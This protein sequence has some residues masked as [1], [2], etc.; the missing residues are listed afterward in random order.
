MI[1]R[2]TLLT[3]ALVCV[4]LAAQQP[5][6]GAPFPLTNTRYGATE[7][8]PM[9]T[10]N[11]QEAFLFW[12]TSR[13]I[14]VTR[15][16]S[17]EKPLGRVV[18]SDAE[19]FT[20]L[21]A[22]THFLLVA[23]RPEKGVPD[24]LVA[25]L[26]D[27]SGEPLGPEFPLLRY[28]HRPA[29]AFNGTKVLLLC[30][31]SA[32][33]EAI[34]LNA[35]GTPASA[36]APTVVHQATYDP[37]NRYFVDADYSVAR[38][39]TGF[40]AAVGVQAMEIVVF[41]SDGTI[42]GRQT[43]SGADVPQY[44][45]RVPAI[46]AGTDNTFFACWR[47]GFGD[48]QALY[49]SILDGEGVPDHV[50]LIERTSSF[51]PSIA[52]GNGYD[53]VYA[54]VSPPSYP[55]TKAHIDRTGVVSREPVGDTAFGA[56]SATTLNNRTLIAWT[57]AGAVYGRDSARPA[58]EAL[59]FGA[60]E[61]SAMTTAAMGDSTL[62]AWHERDGVHAGIR[63]SNGDWSERLIGGGYPLLASSGANLFV[64]ITV[65]DRFHAIRLTAQGEPADSPID[66]ADDFSPTS[67]AWNGSEFALI[68]LDLKYNILAST[69]TPAG[70]VSPS[71][72]LARDT[73]RFGLS[74][75]VI[76]SD[77][78]GFFAAWIGLD[79][80]TFPCASASGVFATRLDADLRRLDAANLTIASPDAC[81]DVTVA[82]DGT[83]YL[84][85]WT[86]YY[87]VLLRRVSTAGVLEPPVLANP[88]APSRHL[89]TTLTPIA[90]GA[91]LAWRQRD[92]PASDHVTLVRNGVVTE[93]GSFPIDV[94]SSAPVLIAGENTLG[95]LVTSSQN[96]APYYGSMRTMMALADVALPPP[97]SPPRATLRQES[98][99][100]LLIEWTAPPEKVNG[101][102]VETLVGPNTW[103]EIDS[104][105]YFRT[106]SLSVTA[107]TLG[108][109]YRFRVRA[110]ND[111][112]TSNPSN[113][114]S[115][116][117]ST[118]RRSVH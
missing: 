112:G 81:D 79:R 114:V 82:W 42:R 9:L 15:W 40:I 20:V 76:A 4:P 59:A 6:F 19:E 86:D 108:V 46:A 12:R 111:A 98:N 25:R 60:I 2:L 117:V 31:T 75:P 102:R 21:W 50:F 14:R 53:V 33:T 44:G 113:E 17:G 5:R 1:K 84:V 71:A 28:A 32:E 23:A 57:S 39:G 56:V 8:E 100:Q 52:A 74:D 49:G 54:V 26:L 104:W 13:N 96:A 78:H 65:S 101:Y 93:I 97:P 48:S 16:V 89:A 64:V 109:T 80:C 29:L 11:G 95:Y 18:L 73:D 88:N 69:L 90:G 10:T 3:F 34:L 92:S 38:K 77:G 22:G 58:P 63:R 43:V 110:W 35:D 51:H 94:S 68:G 37:A 61:Q 91:A 30:Q 55:L 105:F 103:E 62:V 115:A 7:G 36:A 85:A 72:T 116:L 24:S 106:R 118:R 107:A 66:L 41:N 67:I 87:P 70:A 83:H 27:S 47:G 99:G 45:G